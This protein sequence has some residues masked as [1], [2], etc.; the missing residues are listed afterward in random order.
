MSDKNPLYNEEDPRGT[1]YSESTE[2]PY[3]EPN[4]HDPASGHY[5]DRKD[6]REQNGPHTCRDCDTEIPTFWDRCELCAREAGDTTNRPWLQDEN[7]EPDAD[8]ETPDWTFG[9][10]VFAVVPSSTRYKALALGVSAF[11]LADSEALIGYQEFP[12]VDVEPVAAFESSPATH[13]TAGWG[14][15]VDIAPLDSDDGERLFEAAVERTV[16]A[17]GADTY[18]YLT[19]GDPISSQEEVDTL[20]AQIEAGDNR[21]WI[22]PGIVRRYKSGPNR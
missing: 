20:R 16:Q 18:F 11:R 4:E 12:D 21:Y 2:D 8:Q 19:E 15:V 6:Q 13:L 14:D 1:V 22:V 9:R 3:A 17:S 10:V 5:P 7:S